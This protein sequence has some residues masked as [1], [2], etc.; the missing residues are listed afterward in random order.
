[1]NSLQE[2]SACGQSVWLDYLSRDLLRGGELQRLIAADGISGVTT[3][4]SIFQVSIG[5]GKSYQAAID[6][7]ARRG[8][9]AES[10]ARQLTIEDVVA[11]A[12]VF[13]PVY[14]R[15]LGKDGFVS[16]EVPPGLAYDR[17]GTVR[18]ARALWKALARPNVMIKVPATP[19]GISATR[20]LLT[21][22]INVNST[23]LFWLDSYSR[24]QEAYLRALEGRVV[25]GL[26]LNSVSSVASFFLSRID[27]MLDPILAEI[28]AEGTP[29]GN[30]AATLVGAVAVACAKLA[31]RKFE[32]IFY[33]PR[34]ANLAVRGAR[35]QRLLWASTSTKNP[36]YPDTKYVDPLIGNDTVTTLP[37][38]TL[39]VFKAHGVARITL[40]NGVR[41][42]DAT[43]EDLRKVGIDM[44]QIGKRLEQEG[45]R[46]FANASAALGKG[47]KE[48]TARLEPA[49]QS[50]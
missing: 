16:I 7:L 46:K 28:V 26:P 27:S 3:N 5:S 44:H 43:I 13:L 48:R 15:T 19:A 22:G 45:V 23:L 12:D 41:A 24:V 2:L 36:S 10:I 21:E 29:S 35:V 20:Q 25:M 39:R 32:E 33:G 18:E 4:P 34:F 30:K 1:M 42:A 8:L 50:R 37:L 14:K 6:R 38:E 49:G 40:S 17:D 9:N 31:Y 47:I 11:T